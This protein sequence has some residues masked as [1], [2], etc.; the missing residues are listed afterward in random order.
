MVGESIRLGKRPSREGG[1]VDHI[2]E[3]FGDKHPAFRQL[4]VSQRRGLKAV[5]SNRPRELALEVL[6]SIYGSDTPS[7][8]TMNRWLRNHRREVIRALES[9]DL[10]DPLY[11]AY[12][13][14]ASA[15]IDHAVQLAVSRLT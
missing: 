12:Q 10:D 13:R 15:A 8:S 6:R 7:L 3:A 2:V 14:G 1:G 11:R 4:S 5:F 9:E